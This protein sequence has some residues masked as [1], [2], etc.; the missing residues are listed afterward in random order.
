[1]ARSNDDD[2]GP[3]LLAL[4]ALALGVGAVIAIW[5][6]SETPADRAERER[7]AGRPREERGSFWSAFT[8]SE[9][10]DAGITLPGTPGASWSGSSAVPIAE[11]EEDPQVLAMR[12]SFGDD[13]GMAASFTP[14]LHAGRAVVAA[15]LAGVNRS[16][17]CD[18]RVLPVRSEGGFNCVVR[19]RCD[20]VTVYPDSALEAG[21][22]PCEVEG[23]VP[24]L[25][26]DRAPSDRDGDPE[27]LVD[28]S[29][30]RVRVH[31]VRHGAESTVEIELD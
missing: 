18:V 6:A 8:Q 24:R 23:G 20:G 5:S 29:G 16:A 13:A 31:D 3:G 30:R 26:T 4:G 27:L 7:E 15:G 28:L 22:A 1:M 25:A 19:V 11:G 9:P 2:L 14:Y 21:Y 10:S 12:R 17:S